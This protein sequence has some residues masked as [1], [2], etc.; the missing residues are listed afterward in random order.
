MCG[1]IAVLNKKK[2]Y[3]NLFAPLLNS[4][5]RLEYR[6]YDSAGI[7][8]MDSRN[9]TTRIRSI[10]RIDGLTDEVSKREQIDS[11]SG[12][13][14][15]R[16]ATHG[17]ITI[18]N[19]HPHT[20]GS[21]SVVHNGIVENYSRI[22]EDLISR[23]NNFESETDTEVISQLISSF[24]ADGLSFTD[25]FRKMLG[26]IEGAS[27]I[28]AMCDEEPGVVIGAMYGSPLAVG[29]S[30]EQIYMASDA[31]ALHSL[32][33]NITYMESGELVLATTDGSFRIYD[34][35][36]NVIEKKSVRIGAD[37]YRSINKLMYESY[38]LTEIHEEPSVVLDTYNGFS[39]H[40]DIADYREVCFIACGTSYYAGLLGKYWLEDIAKIKANVEIASEFRYRN[41]VLSKD[42]LYIFISQ[43]GETM[44]TLYA[45][46]QINSL[47]YDTLA[48]VNV[49]NSSIYREAKNTIL[50]NAGPEMAVASTKAFVCQAL[51]IL[52]LAMPKG[53]LDI[54]AIAASMQEAIDK[55]ELLMDIAQK[56]SSSRAVFYMGRGTSYPISLE[57]ALKMKEISYI[58]SEGYPAGEI[59][60]GPIAIIDENV[61]TVVLAPN[62]KHFEKTVS[63]TQEIL[64]RNGPVL[65]IGANSN[66][67]T[68]NRN[69]DVFEI[70]TSS[71]S[72][73][74][75]SEDIRSDITK[76]FALATVVHLLAYY[77]AKIRGL[78]VDKPRNLAKSVTVE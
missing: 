17:G 71:C 27:A 74:I 64:A 49:E 12:I 36:M 52:L 59:K 14:H 15:T 7:A 31:I 73:N 26:I 56:I 2:K 10:N 11:I 39:T 37:S 63:N 30:N 22:K 16:W 53:A 32:S 60:H 44:D 61:Y 42:C 4:L 68:G 9:V 78:D 20:T 8:V 23:G 6:G 43:S 75:P 72:P 76:P 24:M 33:N 34:K 35:D 29:H 1:I 28:V 55:K 47:G 70:N 65:V 77:T 21:V 19:A 69:I 50:L 25:S 62:D 54:E 45:M 5:R 66:V 67:W 38:M 3:S 51:T 58:S 46:R 40:V 48:I 18:S 41:P 57:G 13:G